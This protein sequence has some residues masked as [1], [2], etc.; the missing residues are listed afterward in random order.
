MAYGVGTFTIAGIRALCMYYSSFPPYYHLHAKDLV[1][2]YSTTEDCLA[3]LGTKRLARKMLAK[4][5]IIFFNCL[6]KTWQK[7]P[8]NLE[9]ICGVG[10]F[11]ELD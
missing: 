6:S 7:D 3:D 2:S 9:H 1:L 4:F 5:A 11:A 10:V 8:D